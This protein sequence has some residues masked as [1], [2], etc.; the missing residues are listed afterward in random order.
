MANISLEDLVKLLEMYDVEE[1]SGVNI[2]GDIEIELSEGTDGSGVVGLMLGQE[3]TQ[4]AMGLLNLA[5]L[6]G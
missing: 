3:I 6:S 1:I 2:E 4:A 5:R